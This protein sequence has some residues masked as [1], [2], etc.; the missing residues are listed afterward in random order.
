MKSR[1]NPTDVMMNLLSL[2]PSRTEFQRKS[3]KFSPAPK[4]F[5]LQRMQSLPV[6]HETDCCDLPTKEYITY[7]YRKVHVY[8]L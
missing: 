2:A 6:C 4:I 3:F 1:S 8:I 5:D 7:L